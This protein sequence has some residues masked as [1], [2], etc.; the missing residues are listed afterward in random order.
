[1]RQYASFSNVADAHSAYVKLKAAEKPGEI[2][3]VALVEVSEK[4][5]LPH[6]KPYLVSWTEFT[7]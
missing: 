4:A 3:N 6:E 5:R 1:M 7:S 2:E